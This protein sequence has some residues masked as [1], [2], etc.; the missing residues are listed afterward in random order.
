MD[1]VAKAIKLQQEAQRR[2]ALAP[3]YDSVRREFDLKLADGLEADARDLLKPD[4][5]LESSS[6][7]ELIPPSSMGLQG[8]ESVIRAPDLLN[9]GASS[10][11]SDLIERAGVLEL[12]LETSNE[13]KA[14]G[15]IQKMLAHQ[16]AAAHK[17]GLELMAESA[18]AKDPDIACKKARVAAKMMDAF[19]RAALTLERLQTGASQVVT[20]QHLQV[21]GQAVIG[22]IS[23]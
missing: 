5:P 8:L 17:R 23:K 12:A 6:C 22:N 7:G 11:R 21:N 4:V 2:R 15:P 18:Q 20:V 9:L 13:I 16:L 19:S 10:Q 14:K 1:N 3:S